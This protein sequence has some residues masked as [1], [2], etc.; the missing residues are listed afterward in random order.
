MSFPIQS[1]KR[2]IGILQDTHSFPLYHVGRR[3][4]VCVCVCVTLGRTCRIVRALH[5]RYQYTKIGSEEAKQ[6][7]WWRRELLGE[8][9]PPVSEVQLRPI[10]EGQ[11]WRWYNSETHFSKT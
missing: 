11:G 1:Y 2:I 6:G 9:F 10:L 5:Y 8:Y 7:Q 3:C 4:M